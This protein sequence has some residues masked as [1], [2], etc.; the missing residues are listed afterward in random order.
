MPTSGG[1]EDEA[2]LTRMAEVFPDRTVVG[3]PG[4]TLSYGG[5]SPQHPFSP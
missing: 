3:V 4:A 1:P 5:A 2:A